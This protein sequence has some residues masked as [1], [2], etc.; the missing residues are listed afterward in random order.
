[1]KMIVMLAVA[2]ASL[3]AVA[4]GLDSVSYRNFY[5]EH[6]LFWNGSSFTKYSQNGKSYTFKE[7]KAVVSFSREAS[8]SYHEF[9]KDRTTYGILL[10]S[11]ALLIGGALLA[12]SPELKGGLA[13]GG[14]LSATIALPVGKRSFYNL[15]RTI[16]I[17]N[18]EMMLQQIPGR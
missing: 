16:W 3:P 10:V 1:M 14:V 5:N 12:K 4:Q 6:A 9:M 2:W 11:S 18:R 17:Y 8:L 13:I 7:M 15:N